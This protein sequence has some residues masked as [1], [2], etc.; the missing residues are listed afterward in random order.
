MHHATLCLLLGLIEVVVWMILNLNF[1]VFRGRVIGRQRRS[2]GWI[3]YGDPFSAQLKEE[4]LLIPSLFARLSFL[5][6]V[7][8][9]LLICHLH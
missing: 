9:Y 4:L 8:I 1:W 6:S 7:L 2:V 5:F 3:S